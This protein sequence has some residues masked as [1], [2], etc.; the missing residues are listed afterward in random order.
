MY[1]T[2]I[3]SISGRLYTDTDGNMLIAAGNKQIN[4]GSIVWTDGRIIYGFEEE[5]GGGIVPQPSKMVVPIWGY[6]YFWEVTDQYFYYYDISLQ[7]LIRSKK[8]SEITFEGN[9]SF[10]M[11]KNGT[12]KIINGSHEPNTGDAIFIDDADID[13]DGN[14]TMFYRGVYSVN[15]RLGDDTQEVE[16]LN[17]T[18]EDIIF[19]Q[20]LVVTTNYG[21]GS[22]YFSNFPDVISELEK[23]V[24]N[25]SLDDQMKEEIANALRD[26]CSN[27]Q[28][29]ENVDVL[30][31]PFV[32]TYG[33]T[34]NGRVDADGNKYVYRQDVT[35]ATMHYCF[36]YDYTAHGNTTTLWKQSHNSVGVSLS[37]MNYIGKYYIQDGYYKATAVSYDVYGPDGLLFTLPQEAGN[38][39]EITAMCKIGTDKYL[40]ISY[41]GALFTID[42]SGD[43]V[44][45]KRL[46]PDDDETFP[47]RFDT[48]MRLRPITMGQFNKI[49]AQF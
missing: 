2:E 9:K 40:C 12:F 13:G 30:P 31:D 3:K 8:T 43:A 10:V 39:L 22:S 38:V 7:K 28:L 26:Y 41:G 1:Q 17:H 27:F 48:T 5:A 47:I 29:I 37:D 4:V 24:A 19:P 18:E 11:N 46:Y 15:Q 34:V 35:A 32:M 21:D 6:N 25:G 36:T 45:Y 44:E 16:Y 33:A 23:E 49:L 14:V 42:A 20:G